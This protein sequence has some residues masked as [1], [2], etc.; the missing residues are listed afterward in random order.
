M[1]NVL[2]FG[3]GFV[4]RPMTE[5]L[6]S[7]DIKVHIASRTLSKA[8]NLVKGHKNGVAIKFDIG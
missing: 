5:Y 7:H 1:K 6:M 3:A 2:I 4:S 8:E